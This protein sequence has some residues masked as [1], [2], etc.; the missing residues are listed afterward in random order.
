MTALNI[1]VVGRND[2]SSLPVRLYK[3]HNAMSK[4]SALSG[5]TFEP[6]FLHASIHLKNIESGWYYK[7]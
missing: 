6:L 4:S 5:A 1:S 7:K 2:S 3:S